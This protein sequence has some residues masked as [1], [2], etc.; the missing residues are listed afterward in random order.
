MGFPWARFAEIS[1]Q[2][3]PTVFTLAG[4]PFLG[5]AA[6]VAIGEAQQIAGASNADKK[7]HVMA[8]LDAGLAGTNS[9]LVAH[10]K[11]PVKTDDVMVLA[12]TAIDTT[13]QAVKLVH[14]SHPDAGVA[15]TP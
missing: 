15:G 14:D 12:A 6:G 1:K 7:A 3:A 8:A 9:V 13:V 4:L 5:Q 10:G 11:P 2:L